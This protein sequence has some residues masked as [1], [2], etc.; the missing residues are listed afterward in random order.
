MRRR[1][2]EHTNI[3]RIGRAGWHGCY[4]VSCSPSVAV[5]NTD[6]NGILLADVGVAIDVKQG[7]RDV[8]VS[9]KISVVG[10]MNFTKAE[11]RWV[12]IW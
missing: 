7:E 12:E 1:T 11:A 4:I 6:K 2:Q 10:A 9:G 8:N 5:F 3:L